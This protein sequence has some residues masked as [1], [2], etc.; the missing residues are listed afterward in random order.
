VL[1][2]PGECFTQQ[3]HG[4]GDIAAYQIGVTQQKCQIRIR[5]ARDVARRLGQ[6]IDKTH[7]FVDPPS[8]TTCAGINAAEPI[9][10]V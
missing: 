1:F 10:H 2:N 8:Q 4:T 5:E 6:F 9:T 7:T 3:L